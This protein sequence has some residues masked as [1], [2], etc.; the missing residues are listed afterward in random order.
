MSKYNEK[1]M[2]L[3]EEDLEDNEELK[4]DIP[5]DDEEIEE[6]FKNL[7]NEEEIDDP[8][9]DDLDE[10]ED[11]EEEDGVEVI[12]SDDPDYDQPIILDKD[13][14]V[15]DDTANN[16]VEESLLSKDKEENERIEKY[17]PGY[18]ELR[19]KFLDSQLL[20]PTTF[21]P[22]SSFQMNTTPA[23][24]APD[25]SDMGMSSANGS[26]DVGGVVSESAI[27]Y[28]FDGFKPEFSVYDVYQG[29]L[30]TDAAEEF[31]IATPEAKEVRNKEV[32]NI[33]ANETF[34]NENKQAL[35]I[36]ITKGIPEESIVKGLKGKVKL[37]NEAI[38]NTFKLESENYL[39]YF[40]TNESVDKMR[41]FLAE[42]GKIKNDQM[43]CENCGNELTLNE[44]NQLVCENCSKEIE[45]TIN[46]SKEV[47]EIICNECG[48]QEEVDPNVNEDELTCENCGSSDV[49]FKT[50]VINELEETMNPIQL[51]RYVSSLS[52][53]MNENLDI[54]ITNETYDKN[55][56]LPVNY[57]PA[58]LL[59]NK[60]DFGEGFK[61]VIVVAPNSNK[62]IKVLFTDKEISRYNLKK[63]FTKQDVQRVNNENKS[64]LL[65]NLTDLFGNLNE[66]EKDKLDIKDLEKL[67]ESISSLLD[68][69]NNSLYEG[70]EEDLEEHY[71]DIVFEGYENV[72]NKDT[73]ILNKIVKEANSGDNLRLVGNK[74]ILN[75]DIVMEDIDVDKIK[76]ILINESK[77]ES[78]L[79]NENSFTIL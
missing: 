78:D 3:Y 23:N 55:S 69:S 51:V 11:A 42:T 7:I 58:S 62:T 77:I 40:V 47:A 59:V 5:E 52:K 24:G 22:E 26:A 56:E 25:V 66:E 60:V 50:K 74:L 29:V 8:E 35:P 19:S 39:Q 57:K 14:T 37:T 31:T 17:Q 44:E 30:D 20:V 41:K 32:K 76:N 1:D 71:E 54:V 21:G 36:L 10:V 33:I 64:G 9:T 4:R 75:K 28:L 18:T 16:E 27:G 67:E 61:K 6:A 73:E 63:H 79:L 72:K 48:N 70:I 2:F 49:E 45:E 12:D 34:V 65:E 15:S 53:T 43:I 38:L 13:E 46:P 68:K